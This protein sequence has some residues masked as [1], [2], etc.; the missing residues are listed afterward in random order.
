MGNGNKEIVYG[1][2]GQIGGSLAELFEAVD[3]Q[4]DAVD[5]TYRARVIDT[6]QIPSGREPIAWGT[7]R[8]YYEARRQPIR[9]G[10][11]SGSISFR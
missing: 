10:S 1:T 6:T 11:G 3:R 2:A 7:G 9:T 5:G 4:M 8:I